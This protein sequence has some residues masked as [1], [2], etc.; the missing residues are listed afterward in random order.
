MAL[1]VIKTQEED[2]KMHV[3]KGKWEVDI[4]IFCCLHK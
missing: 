1:V 2:M 3:G 4:I